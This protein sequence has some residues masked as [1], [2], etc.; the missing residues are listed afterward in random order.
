M[1]MSHFFIDRPIFA[2]VI[3]ILLT[4]AG[5]IAQRSLPVAEYPEIAPPTVNISTYYP[6]ASAEVIAETV[7]TP[8]EQKV[9]GVDDMLYMTSQSTGDGKLS[10]DVVFKAG[11]DVDKAQ[12]L[13]QNRVAIATPRLPQEVIRQGVTVQK[14]SPD[15]MMVVH[16]ISPDGSRDQ[17][18]ISNYATLYVKDALSRVDGVGNVQILGARDYSMRVWLDPG[19]VAARGLTAGDVVA[20]IQA[21]NIQVAAGAINQP[22]TEPLGGFQISVQ[23]LGRLSDPKQ[24][25]DIVVRADADGDIRLRDVARVELGAQDYTIN[26]YLDRD[27]ATALLIFQRP[28]SNA[29][30]TAAGVK[31]V[32]QEAKTS[33]PPGLDYTIVYNPTE[34]IQE[35]VDEVVRTLFEAVGLVVLVVI[36]FLQTWRAA[37]IPVIAIPV[38]LIGCFFIMSGAG[39]TFNSLSLFGIVLAIGIVVDDAIVVVENVE[40]Y[41]EHGMS[42][43]EA[44]HRTMDEVGGALLAIALVLCAVF[45]PVAYIAG[46]L[47]QAVRDHNSRRDAHL[48]IRLIDVVAG[49]G[50]HPA[51]AASGALEAVWP[52]PTPH[53][54]NALELRRLQLGFR[55][56]QRRL[57]TPDGAAHPNGHDPDHTLCRIDLLRVRSAEQDPDRPHPAAGSRLPDR[58]VPAAAWRISR[59]HR[60]SAPSSGGHHSQAQGRPAR[61]SLCRL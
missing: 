55:Q 40:R 1:R 23:T 43:K 53:A 48:R 26:T 39:L 30:A 25:G 37:I 4:I 21:A 59:A 61:R 35:S 28:G 17:N 51:Q 50:G 47:L 49:D 20:A 15:L 60:Q 22:P 56:A 27:V 9:N 18:Y 46:R 58:R 31:A 14:A 29:L 24:F 11:T 16:M 13:V 38:S 54:S 12:V 7:A 42:P 57:R 6:G 8:I 5:A 19:K 52:D 10:I 3:S 36:V 41:L 34:F 32:M 45:I 33:F 2:A 44:A